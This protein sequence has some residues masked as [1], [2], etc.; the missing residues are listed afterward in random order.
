MKKIAT[1]LLILITSALS[2]AQSI[3]SISV[4]SNSN[5]RPEEPIGHVLL[6]ILFI[7]FLAVMLVTL[8]KYFLDFRLKNKLIDRGMAEQLA[9]HLAGKNPKEKQHD[10]IKLA[11][12]FFGVGLGLTVTYFTSPVDIHSIAIMAFCIGLSYLVYFLYLRSAS[13]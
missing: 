10:T 11:L 4:S 2:F 6:P 5:I 8:I 1:S 3:P 7:A 13:K 9:S 12:L